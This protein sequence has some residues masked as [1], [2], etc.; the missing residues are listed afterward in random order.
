MKYK[1]VVTSRQ[2]GMIAKNENYD[3]YR[4]DRKLY[5]YWVNTP[6][7]TYNKKT[8]YTGRFNDTVFR[9]NDDYSA[10]VGAIIRLPKRLTL[11]EYIKAGTGETDKALLSD[12]M[13]FIATREDKRYIYMYYQYN[14]YS[15]D[16]VKLLSRYDKTSKSLMENI[17]PKIINDWDGG[18]DIEWEPYSQNENVLVYMEFPDKIKKALSED[19]TGQKEIIHPEKREELMK[20]SGNA[21]DDDNQIVMII[22]L[23]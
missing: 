4:S 8:Y 22:K 20:I 21:K 2:N 13:S 14:T 12:R 10:S 7:Y 9:I 3:L 23:K 6:F 1:Y 5:T 19:K 11:E 16:N 15:K 18:M 17:N